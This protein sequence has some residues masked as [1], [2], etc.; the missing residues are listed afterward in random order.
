[1][2]TCS[3]L[4]GYLLCSQRRQTFPHDIDKSRTCQA[5]HWKTH[6]VDC[7]VNVAIKENAERMGPY[8]ARRFK[9]FSLWCGKNSQFLA[10]AALSALNV[11]HDRERAGMAFDNCAITGNSQI[12]CLPRIFC[13]PC[14]LGC[15]HRTRPLS[16]CRYNV[17]IYGQGCLLHTSRAYP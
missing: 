14:L 12:R 4:C 17:R 15:P 3:I 8:H 2:Q 5:T 1:M 9:C 6:K 13:L 11:M 16:E 7:R 10:T